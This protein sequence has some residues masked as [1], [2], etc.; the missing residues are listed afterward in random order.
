MYRII[1]MLKIRKYISSL[2]LKIN[3]PQNSILFSK[4]YDKTNIV[5]FGNPLQI[6]NIDLIPIFKLDQSN[7]NLST[8]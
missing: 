6:E 5:V 4:L 3:V 8:N 7:N 2:T 1:S